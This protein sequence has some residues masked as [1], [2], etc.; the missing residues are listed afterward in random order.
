MDKFTVQCIACGDFILLE[1]E[2]GLLPGDYVL[3]ADWI[4]HP[5]CWDA[6][7]TKFPPDAPTDNMEDDW[8]W[9]P[10]T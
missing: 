10:K 2:D 8:E 1:W 5:V 7:I 3:I 6:L 4:Y 9:L